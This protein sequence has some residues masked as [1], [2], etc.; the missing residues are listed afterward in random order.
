MGKRKSGIIDVDSVIG[1]IDKELRGIDELLIRLSTTSSLSTAEFESI[2]DRV[3]YLLAYDPVTERLNE[4]AYSMISL[5]TASVNDI[6]NVLHQTRDSLIQTR[7]KMIANRR[8]LD[9]LLHGDG[10]EYEDEY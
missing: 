3:R 4:H 5:S 10:E 9:W 6:W 8:V 2:K 7:F 1:R